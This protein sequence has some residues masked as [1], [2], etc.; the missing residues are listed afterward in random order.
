MLTRSTHQELPTSTT[1]LPF[2]EAIDLGV[3][4]VVFG[5][6]RPQEDIPQIPVYFR[7]A[8]ETVIPVTHSVLPKTPIAA[9]H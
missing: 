1:N 9:I 4:V 7:D 3:S 2:G 6:S 8:V 5:G